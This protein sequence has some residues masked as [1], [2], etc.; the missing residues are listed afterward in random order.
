LPFWAASLTTAHHFSWHRSRKKARLLI[1]QEE[2][3]R[4]ENEKGAKKKERKQGKCEG[5][6]PSDPY[7][8]LYFFSSL[9]GGLPWLE[10][11]LVVSQQAQKGVVIS[12]S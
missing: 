10:A 5:T 8:R 6:R 2:L 7:Q 4:L 3:E 1:L 11:L 12:K 9:L